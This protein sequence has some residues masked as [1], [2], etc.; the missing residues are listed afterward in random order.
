[1]QCLD[2]CTLENGNQALGI[3]MKH[4]QPQVVRSP[5]Q[6]FRK[7]LTL[8]RQAQAAQNWEAK[9]LLKQHAHFPNQTGIAAGLV[10]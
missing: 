9:V 4:V 5:Y 8:L 3:S 6:T 1:M 2:Y 10:S 7:E